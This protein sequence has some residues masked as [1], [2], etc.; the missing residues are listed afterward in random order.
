MQREKIEVL[1]TFSKETARLYG[2]QLLALL[3]DSYSTDRLSRVP[4]FSASYNSV[5]YS[6]ILIHLSPARELPRAAAAV[7][8][9]ITESKFQLD[10]T[11]APDSF[12]AGA[13]IGVSYGSV[14]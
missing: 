10:S 7:K 2:R 6:W 9:L 11:V 14:L 4:P 1:C 12:T 5:F 8:Y 3:M 13:R